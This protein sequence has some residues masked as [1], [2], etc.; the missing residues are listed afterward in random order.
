MKTKGTFKPFLAMLLIFSVIMFMPLAS[1]LGEKTEFDKDKPIKGQ[2][3]IVDN[4][5]LPFISTKKATYLITDWTDQCV[6]DCY[7]EFLIALE[8]TDKI[9]DGMKFKDKKGE[10]RNNNFNVYLI[11][12][13]GEEYQVQLY[14]AVCNDVW[15][16]GNETNSTE[17]YYQEQCVQVENGYETKYRE[18]KTLYDYSPL[19]AGIYKARLEVKKDAMSS[20]DAIPIAQGIDLEEWAWF[21]ASWEYKRELTNITDSFITYFNI[22]YDSDMQS[23]FDDIRFLNGAEDTELNY[24]LE[25]KVDGE[26]ADFR[27]GTNNE[28]AWMYYGNDDATYNGDFNDTYFDPVAYY[29]LDEASGTVIDQANDYDGT[30]SGSTTGVDGQIR[31]NYNFTETTDYIDLGESEWDTLIAGTFSISLWVKFDTVID[32]KTIISK[33]YD[34]TKVFSIGTGLKGGGS[35][36]KIGIRYDDSGSTGSIEGT[37]TIV[38]GTWYHVVMT[39]N[40]SG[41]KLYINNYEEINTADTFSSSNNIH[42]TI[43]AGGFNGLGNWGPTYGLIDEVGIYDKILTL[44]QIE[45]LYLTTQPTGFLGAEESSAGIS[46]TLNSPADSLETNNSEVTFNCSAVATGGLEVDNMTLYVWGDSDFTNFTATS[47]TSN[48]STWTNTLSDGN[49]TWNC[50]SVADDS[51]EDWGTSNRT[52]TVDT[53]PNIQ[54]ETPTQIDNYNSSISWIPINVSVTETYFK[55]I[56]FNGYD[57]DSSFTYVYTYTDSTRFEN[58]TDAYDGTWEYN[59]TVCTTTNKCN[60]TETRTINLDTTAPNITII[61]PTNNTIINGGSVDINF[62]ATD[63]GIGI[64]SCWAHLSNPITWKR[65]SAGDRFIHNYFGTSNWVYFTIDLLGGYRGYNISIPTECRINGTITSDYNE[66]DLYCWNGTTNISILHEDIHLGAHIIYYDVLN[67]SQSN[68]TASGNLI[69]DA[70]MIIYANDTVGNIGSSSIVNFTIVNVSTSSGFNAL[71]VEGSYETYYNVINA[72]DTVSVTGVLYYNGTGYDMT[73]VSSNFSYSLLLPLNTNYTEIRPVIFSQNFTFNGVSEVFNTTSANQTV[74]KVD[75]NVTTSCPSGMTPAFN[76]TFADEQNLSVQ[77]ATSI[78]YNLIYGLTGVNTSTYTIYGSVADTN[79]LQIC[80]NESDSG[81]SVSYGE[82]QY[83]IAGDV[84]RRYYLFDGTAFTNDT[85]ATVLYGLTDYPVAT[86]FQITAQTTTLAVYDDHY[87]SLLRWYPDLNEYK[88]VEMGKTDEKGQSVLNAQT[89][90]VDYRI[91]IY[92]TSGTLVQL[93][94]PIRMVCQVLPCTY[95]IYVS[96]SVVDPTVWTAIQQSLEFNATTSVF[97]FIWNDPSQ[98]TSLINLTVWADTFSTSTLVCSETSTSFTGVLACN[99]SG[100][101]GILRAEAWRSAS[102]PNLL[103]QNI[104]TLKT[105]FTSTS[106]GKSLGL[107]LGAILVV[108]FAF[109]GIFS[110]VTMIILSVVALIPLVFLGNITYLIFGGFVI[111]AFICLHFLKRIT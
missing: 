88:I 28:S 103:A 89:N 90:D 36:D 33:W 101:S 87:L 1:S 68:F 63:G 92:Q 99:V 85:I 27:V 106:E 57:Q 37:N 3:D 109:M 17:G 80:I 77:N 67:C 19:K 70:S 42:L 46:T 7:G 14:E 6:Q 86:A 23:D 71:T 76:F 43:G 66:T 62:T 35:V 107:I 110:P 34:G 98:D 73:N 29:Y 95:T 105:Y 78:S 9:F 16:E 65:I 22:T 2:I 38:A 39:K 40:A 96:S 100:E 64:D 84:L 93:I 111:I 108:F 83:Q 13:N 49:W 61:L 30:N 54:F 21:N 24:T 74:K 56:T 31:T 18:S 10:E 97:T 32:H 4:W 26:W 44:D 59:V 58:I 47:G 94:D 55:N 41:M 5:G 20:I 45:S 25:E 15:I 11:E 60:T 79:I 69:G 48:T 51:Q 53:T 12:E 50:L 104:Q 102:P 82:I 72:S 52:L 91:G 75:F 81:L 8:Q